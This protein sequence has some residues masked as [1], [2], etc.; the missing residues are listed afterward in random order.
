MN[1]IT[2]TK[3]QGKIVLARQIAMYILKTKYGLAYKKIGM[4]FGNRDH[5]TVISS[6][7]KIENEMLTNGDLKL[8]ID[9]INK[10]I[11]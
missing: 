9:T 2:G 8:A 11:N 6:V 10:K 1:D 7:E 5:S 4:L 3:R